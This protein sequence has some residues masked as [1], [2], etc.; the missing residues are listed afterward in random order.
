MTRVFTTVKNNYYSH[1]GYSN[2]LKEA[3]LDSSGNNIH[4][5]VSKC[6]KNIFYKKDVGFLC[7]KVVSVD[8]KMRKVILKLKVMYYIYFSLSGS[9]GYGYV[10]LQ[11]LLRV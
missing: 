5:R 11:R 3:Y 4:I 7:K 10:L 2:Y 1:T 6:F 8:G 9:E